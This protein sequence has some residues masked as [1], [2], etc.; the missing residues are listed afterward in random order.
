M[1][2]SK[3]GHARRT[4]RGGPAAAR[5]AARRRTRP[6]SRLDR[7]VVE[8]PR[9][10]DLDDVAPVQE[11]HPVGDREPLGLVVG[12]VEGRSRRSRP[13]RLDDLPP[14]LARCSASRSPSGSS[15]RKTS[16][17]GHERVADADQAR[18]RPRQ[19]GPAGG[20]AAGPDRS[21]RARPETLART[22]GLGHPLHLQPPAE[23]VRHVEEGDERGRLEDHGRP[24][25][26]PAAGPVT[27]AAPDRTPRRDSTGP[28]RRGRAAAWTCRCRMRP[29]TTISS[30]SAAC[31]VTSRSTGVPSR[32]TVTPRGPC[33]SSAPP[34]QRRVGPP[35][36]PP[37]VRLVSNCRERSGVHAGPRRDVSSLYARPVPAQR[38][39]GDARALGSDRRCVLALP[40]G[41][42]ARRRRM[43]RAPLRRTPRADGA[44]WIVLLISIGWLAGLLAAAIRL[45]LGRSWA[46]LAR[47][48]EPS[49]P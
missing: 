17:A 30:P 10:A 16:G 11:G 22:S 43:G 4:P 25:G 14:D 27:S 44:V 20:R 18:A 36:S 12:H 33:R 41:L 47:P 3:A 31:S 38:P 48:P 34:L 13:D 28:G 40:T 42:R 39:R 45:L 49:S 6:T 32:T 37:M 15:S 2:T 8:V 21:W 24:V 9:P 46:A 29:S 7:P 5:S 19:S 23:V 26:P 35:S 1:P